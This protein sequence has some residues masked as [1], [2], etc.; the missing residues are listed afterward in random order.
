MHGSKPCPGG[1]WFFLLQMYRHLSGCHSYQTAQP[2]P[3]PASPG[4]LSVNMA[5]VT[6]PRSC[7]VTSS[8]DTTSSHPLITEATTR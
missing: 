5:T 3:R 1:T 6:Q 7:Q 8:P 4:A 2:H